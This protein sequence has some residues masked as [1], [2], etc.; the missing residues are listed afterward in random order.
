MAVGSLEDPLQSQPADAAP[1]VVASHIL[2]QSESQESILATNQSP[3]NPLK[4]QPAYAALA[5]HMHSATIG[6]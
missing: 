3:G 1:A 2:H 6:V 5:S 4:S